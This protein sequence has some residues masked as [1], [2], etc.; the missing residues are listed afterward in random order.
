VKH[1]RPEVQLGFAGVSVLLR[2][3]L[4]AVLL[5][6]G[7]GC[8]KIPPGR[9]AIDDVSVRGAQAIDPDEL[10]GKLATAR[11]S[12]FLGLFRGVVYDYEIYDPTVLQRDLAR[13]ERYYRGRGFFEAHARAG[14]VEA[15]G[16]N[17]VRIEIVVEEGPPTTNRAIRIDGLEGLP[18]KVADAAREAARDALREGERFDED[19][20]AKAK[21]TVKRALTD[22]G[23]AWADVASDAT[24]DVGARAV[25]Y[26]FVAK[27]GP[28]ARFGTVTI[29]GINGEGQEIEEAPMR[30]AI[31]IE[32][33]WEYSTKSIDE[34]TQALLDLEVFSSVEVVPALPEPPPAD[35]VVPI[36]VR[37]EPT[38]LRQIRA[39]FGAE[40]D[41]LKTEVH[42][43]GGWEDHNF[44]GG[45]R[46]FTVDFQ[47]GVVLFPTRI[48][49]PVWPKKPLPQE[50]LRL[51]LRQPA[52]FEQRTNAFVKPELN[53]FP[54]L[55]PK[56][57][58]TGPVIDYVEAR[59][60]IGVDRPFGKHL[61]GAISHNV[62]A[63]IPFVSIGYVAP[64][65]R[66]QTLVLSYPDLLVWLD[67]RD[68]KTHP[69]A[70][71]YLQNDLQIAGGPFGGVASDLKIEPTANAYVPLGRKVTLAL[72]TSV[73]FLLPADY[74]D[75]ISSLGTG[76]A[77][78][79]NRDIQIMY[80]RGFFLGGPSSNRGFP[81]RGIAPHGVVG[82]LTPQ[83]ATQ[84]IQVNC[85]PGN[86]NYNSADCVFP[87]GGFTKWEASLETRVAVAGP[88]SVA[89]FCD[90]GDV[91]P[92]KV[93]L[94]FDRLHLSCGLGARYD[95]PVG[96]LRLDV[97]DRIQ[98]LQVLGYK[99]EAAVNATDPTEVVQNGLWSGGWPVA[100]SFGIGEAF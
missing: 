35:P 59:T 21:A 29:V 27:P 77:K 69:H 42:L 3:I 65:E 16:D 31:H 72:H 32:P 52:F 71:F 38:K 8:S 36:T 60:A 30:R 79:S 57:A 34:A 12:K 83:N 11:T 15:V 96:P 4:A 14:R 61:Y 53:V 66:P 55:V 2:S 92:Q 45:L 91:A 28:S 6:C 89:F 67:F 76:D 87:I 64:E 94:R 46:T 70:G 51:S 58:D 24:I 13:I 17:H 23:Y 7:L 82:F 75:S 90:A 100:I 20:Y 84:L 1:V 18:P 63:E 62:Q 19:D 93:R 47:P 33:G 10:G 86:P 50:H 56:M 5:M 99:D 73:G 44:L 48:D 95:T 54:L 22:H 98:P 37:V 9:T 88:F 41:V 74:G 49:N 97:A 25:D 26:A 81:L 85:L 40:Y 39:G 80:F 68:D 43:L 78:A